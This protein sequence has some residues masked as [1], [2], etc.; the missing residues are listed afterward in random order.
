[1]Q[2]SEARELDRRAVTASIEVVSRI[3]V[4]DLTRP[5]PCS[6]WKMADLLAHMTTQHDGFA[7]A[8]A[9]HGADP[10]AW[11]LA[12]PSSDPVAEYTAAAHRVIAAFAAAGAGERGFELPEI[13][14]GQQ[15]PAAL[16]ISFHFIDY[17][18]HGWDV[19]RS[20]G[21]PHVLDADLVAA[22]LPVAR[23]VPGGDRRLVPGAAFGPQ[24][25][26]P[27]AATPLDEILALL[28]RSPTWPDDS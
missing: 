19:A 12:P 22:A 15:F 28:G 6:S 18:V 7:A 9:G 23:A 24:L 5:T 14:A 2:V 27:A 13:A 21:L 11:Q 1:M 17:V 10:R 4:S 26:V 25:A 3:T 20:L 8:A 16:A